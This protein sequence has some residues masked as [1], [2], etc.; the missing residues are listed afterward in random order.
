MQVFILEQCTSLMNHVVFQNVQSAAHAL[1][2]LT[3][4][5]S[6]FL[7]PTEPEYLQVLAYSGRILATMDKSIGFDPLKGIFGC[8]VDKAR[9]SQ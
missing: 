6:Q 2:N 8:W 9:S 1:N 3:V 7:E 5:C 4:T